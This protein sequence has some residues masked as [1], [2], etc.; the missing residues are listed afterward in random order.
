MTENNDNSSDISSEERIQLKTIRKGDKSSES[1]DNYTTE[2]GLHINRCMSEAVYSGFVEGLKP[3]QIMAAS[4]DGKDIY[5]WMQWTNTHISVV[6][7]VEAN[8]ICPQIV[9]KWYE[10]CTHFV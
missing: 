3:Q 4:F 9:F 1:D 8:I 10:N 7:A 2:R 6:L 5:F